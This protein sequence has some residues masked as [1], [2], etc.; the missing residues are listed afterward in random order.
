MP[1]PQTPDALLPKLFGE[2]RERYAARPGGYTR[3]L[4]TEPLNRHQLDQAPSAVLEFV[5]GPADIRF[6]MTAAAVARDEVLGKKVSHEA[7]RINVR[8]V[9]AFRAEGQ[10]KFRELVERIKEQE[11]TNFRRQ[12]AEQTG[13]PYQEGW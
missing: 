4:R 9:T 3:V 5:D 6:A 8:K 2:L 7:T 12:E 1:P 13:K 10:K 11:A